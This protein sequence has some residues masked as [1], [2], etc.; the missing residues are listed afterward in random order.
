[1]ARLTIAPRAWAIL[2]LAGTLAACAS[3]GGARVASQAND[4]AIPAGEARPATVAATGWLRSELYF[5]IDAEPGGTVPSPAE[6]AHWRD[7]LDREVTPRFPDGLTVLDGYGQWRPAGAAMPIRQPA[8]VLV[9]LHE[10]T[11]AR[12]AAIEAIRRAWKRETGHESV[13]WA[14]QRVEVSF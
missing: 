10:D 13:L 2:A 6:E 3:P 4:V 5:G 1:M 7:F 9:L 14:W 12:R 11:P 8:K